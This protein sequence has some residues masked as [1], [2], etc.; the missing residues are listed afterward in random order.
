[1]LSDGF[2]SLRPGWQLFCV[3]TVRTQI[4]DRETQVETLLRQISALVA[5]RQQLRGEPARDGEL[6]QNRVEI[7][8]RQREL[9]HAL[10]E[11]YGKRAA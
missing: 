3:Q 2:P 6:E 10:I 1:M 4:M 9:N 8:R 11:L 5:E 7:A